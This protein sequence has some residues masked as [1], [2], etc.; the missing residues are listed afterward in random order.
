L[1]AEIGQQLLEA[2]TQLK[3][4]YEELF[5]QNQNVQYKLQIYEQLSKVHSDCSSPKQSSSNPTSP[6]YN[7]ITSRR[8]S[9]MSSSSRRRSRNLSLPPCVMLDGSVCN[10]PSSIQARST[11]SSQK[12]IDSASNTSLKDQYLE[13]IKNLEDSISNLERHNEE[14]KKLLVKKNEEVN[15]IQIQNSKLLLIKDGEVFDLKQ[16]LESLMA[17]T[18]K[19][20]MEKNSLTKENQRQA[21]ELDRIEI[22]D[23]EYIQ[24]LL[25][26]INRLDSSLK[27]MESTKEELEKSIENITIEKIEYQNKC[28]TLDKK[29]QDYLYYKHLHDTQAQ[30]IQELNQTIEQQRMQIQNLDFQLYNL[31]MCPFE[32]IPEIRYTDKYIMEEPASLESFQSS[33]SSLSCKRS[34]PQIDPEKPYDPDTIVITAKRSSN[35]TTTSNNHNNN[36]HT[37]CNSSTQA[38][39]SLPNSDPDLTLSTTCLGKRNLYSELK[40]TDWYNNKDNGKGKGYIDDDNPYSLSEEVLSNREKLLKSGQYQPNQRPYDSTS[41][42][43]ERKQTIS[44]N[45]E[46]LTLVDKANQSFANN[47]NIEKLI[48]PQM[49]KNDV[50]SYDVLINSIENEFKNSEEIQMRDNPSS[51]TSGDIMRTED[52]DKNSFKKNND[53]NNTSISSIKP[54]GTSKVSNSNNST[55]DNITNGNN[56]SNR[57]G[58]NNNNKNN[59][60]NSNS[61]IGN[62]QSDL[63]IYNSN[64]NNKNNQSDFSISSNKNNNKNNNSSGNKSA[65]SNMSDPKGLDFDKNSN[66][67]LFDYKKL[68]D[69]IE[70]GQFLN[71]QGNTNSNGMKHSAS[72]NFYQKP[73]KSKYPFIVGNFHALSFDSLFRALE[74]SKLQ[75]NNFIVDPNYSN[76]SNYSKNNRKNNKFNSGSFTTPIIGN[77]TYSIDDDTNPKSSSSLTIQDRDDK[78]IN[79][80]TKSDNS[81]SNIKTSNNAIPGNTTINEDFTSLA[82]NFHS[83]SP[84][85]SLIENINLNN[86]IKEG[87]SNSNLS[88]YTSESSQNLSSFNTNTNNKFGSKNHVDDISESDI[89]LLKNKS[90]FGSHKN[91]NNK[92][93][94]SSQKMDKSSLLSEEG[95]DDTQT[96]NNNNNNNNNNYPYNPA[97]NDINTREIKAKTKAKTRS[98]VGAGTSTDSVTSKNSDRKRKNINTNSNSNINNHGSNP[99][100]DDDLI[101]KLKGKHNQMMEDGPGIFNGKLPPMMGG[102]ALLR[103]EGNTPLNNKVTIEQYRNALNQYSNS[104]NYILRLLIDSWL[105]FLNTFVGYGSNINYDINDMDS[106]YARGYDLQRSLSNL[107]S[108]DSLT[109]TE[110]SSLANS[111][112]PSAASSCHNLNELP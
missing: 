33:T 59:N 75:R 103:A 97:D 58:S 15:N 56:Q 54:G 108:E 2:N 104:G 23:Q 24:D 50:N 37:S 41:A 9:V 52:K 21:N 68:S 29:L 1:A 7:S 101:N 102:P 72:D 30:H 42:I 8:N 95:E 100:G 31:S 106:A 96:N 6:R 10:S 51:S 90:L 57:S 44:S 5:L 92:H 105:R 17:K 93:L 109:T 63:S 18:K 84:L 48:K 110:A 82:K 53:L 11:S 99:R 55:I 20:E 47:K 89:S 28:K 14:L 67:L 62:N 74:L 69:M 27:K 83:T 85:T 34:C 87:N 32:S 4:N 98:K 61:N 111:V 43:S 35:A 12:D 112:I 13:K 94:S 65:D 49:N 71:S 73:F 70:K 38:S 66:K 107:T 77:S 40:G 86:A 64:N 78:N 80:T 39:Q 79:D 3:K 26:R 76:S 91:K 45:N 22:I 88:I 60:S 16:E 25:N 81:L 36:N 19:L 46:A